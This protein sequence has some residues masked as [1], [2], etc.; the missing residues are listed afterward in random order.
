MIKAGGCIKM[1]FR[2]LIEEGEATKAK[3]RSL[4]ARVE[5][6]NSPDSI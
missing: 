2:A 3:V 6:G 5:V 1:L 4:E